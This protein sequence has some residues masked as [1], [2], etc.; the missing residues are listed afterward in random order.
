RHSR[1]TSGLS[2]CGVNGGTVSG[3]VAM[4]LA[5]FFIRLDILLA[6]IHP[7]PLEVLAPGVVVPRVLD[8]SL[9]HALQRDRTYRVEV[10]LQRA[11]LIFEDVVRVL[12]VDA[13]VVLL[14]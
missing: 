7:L 14:G 3:T 1:T 2:V 6:E 11:V 5:C 4:L 9:N 10:L 8:E 13:G 12:R